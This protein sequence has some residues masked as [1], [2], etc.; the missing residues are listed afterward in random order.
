MKGSPEHILRKFWGHENFRGSQREIIRSLLQGKD[1]LVLMPTGSGKSICFQVPALVREGICI[2]V[3]P[4]IAL[5][6]NQVQVLKQ[7]GIKTIGLTGSIPQR[8]MDALLDNCIHGNY[9]FLYLSPERLHQSMVRERIQQMPVNFIA[10]DEAHCISEWGHD[11]RPAYRKCSIL[12][13]LHPSIPMIALTATATKKVADDIA[14]NLQMQSAKVFRDSFERKN[15]EF[16]IENREDKGYAL[17]QALKNDGRS[18]IVYVRTRRDSVLLSKTLN[19]KNGVATYFHGGLSDFGKKE[20]LEAWLTNKV[21]VMV[22]TNAFGMGVDKPDVGTVIHYQLP[23]SIENYYQEAG[24][25]GRDGKPAKA[26]LLLNE[27]DIERSKKQF[28]DSIPNVAF[29]KKVYKKL[30]SNFQIAYG[31]GSG[32]SFGLNFNEF[33]NHYG[34]HTRKTYTAIKLLDQNGIISV[35]ETSQNTTSIQFTAHKRELFHWMEQHVKMGHIVQVLLRT[36]G[37]VFEFETKINPSL[38][39]TKTKESVKFVLHTL[40]K[41]SQD[42]LATFVFSQQDLKIVFLRPREDDATINTIAAN[43]E[44]LNRTKRMKLQSMIAYSK[45]KKRCRL[46]F[47]LDYFDEKMVEP[48]GKCDVCTTNGQQGRIGSDIKAAI[49]GILNGGDKTS[50]EL[51]ASTAFRE[52]DVLNALKELLEDE[53]LVLKTNNTYG[54]Q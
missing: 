8:E 28:Q 36:Y 53:A 26:I 39:A 48:C 12:R 17:K 3:S 9:K 51:V 50:R 45:N 49:M 11:F 14:D 7:K 25:A 21:R 37:G 23:D 47:L 29:V 46:G 52:I 6:E 22:A 44:K 18:A 19:E 16:R 31:E 42:G 33:C 38:L 20:R 40:E 2:V 32:E 13:E 4:L 10:I 34:L 15:I 35:S 43:I 54:I 24:R 5:I 27:N 1:A 41:I 30:N